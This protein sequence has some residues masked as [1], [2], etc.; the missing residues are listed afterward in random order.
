MSTKVI[1][2]QSVARFDMDI[3][4]IS[5]FILLLNAPSSALLLIPKLHAGTENDQKDNPASTCRAFGKTDGRMKGHVNFTLSK[6]GL[7]ALA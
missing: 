4:L 2:L 3:F 6:F 5:A 7:F 1:A